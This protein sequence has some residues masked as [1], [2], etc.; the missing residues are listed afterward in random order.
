MET[1]RSEENF[2]S[3]EDI[4]IITGGRIDLPF[5][6][7]YLQ[8]NRF[9]HIIAVDK[10]LETADALGL[11]PEYVVGDFDTVKP[12]V[13]ARYRGREDVEI[14]AFRPE[15]DLTDTQIALSIA[16]EAGKGTIVMLG[17][18]GSRFDHML[19]NLFLLEEVLKAGRDCVILDENNRIW[20]A[21]RSFILKREEA[22]GNYVSLIPL[23]DT[24]T[25]VTLRGM[26][27]PLADYTL[28]RVKSGLGVSNEIVEET[29]QV[30]FKSGILIVV[31]A[32]D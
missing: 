12:E 22:W 26:K 23:T 21:D 29:A 15:K 17:A 14:R 6:K 1:N 3:T 32:K 9:G 27:Y 11:V 30:E 18:T 31:E 7:E 2:M 20:L 8:K 13:L 28:E 5:V 24:V 19:A 16:G 4:L 25:G 10:G